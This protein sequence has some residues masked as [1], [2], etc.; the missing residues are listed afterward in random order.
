MSSRR[1]AGRNPEFK[2][3]SK[4]CTVATWQPR[5]HRVAV[6]RPE[7]RASG[8]QRLESCQ[9]EPRSP[10]L[11]PGRV[12]RPGQAGAG[13]PRRLAAEAAAIR[14][15]ASAA[16]GRPGAGR[17]PVKDRRRR[18]Q[19]GYSK[20][21]A[22]GPGGGGRGC[23]GC[24]GLGSGRSL[25]GLA[26][27]TIELEVPVIMMARSRCPTPGAGGPGVRR[28]RRDCR[29][30]PRQEPPPPPARPVVRL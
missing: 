18:P 11:P 22:R 12:G 21:R 1:P 24:G 25:P 6:V 8:C 7:R 29:R 10:S 23:G 16:L 19:A 15:D 20:A 14:C 2:D 3:P 26:Q 5:P 13:W 30:A 17:R 9:P 27:A 28:T 4:Y